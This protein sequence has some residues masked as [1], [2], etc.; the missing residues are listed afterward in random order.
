MIYASL[1]NET[2]EKALWLQGPKYRK[3]RW[4]VLAALIFLAFDGILS[5][6]FTITTTSLPNATL[7]VAYSQQL[8]ESGAAATVAWSIS[9]GVLPS[10]LTLDS[11]T[12]VISGT[13][14]SLG[15]ALFQ[16]EAQY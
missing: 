13:P 7:G 16:V 11:S 6:Q 3:M 10:G 14:T 8:Q 5:A 12:G 4:A 2:Y 15:T 1:C 9:S